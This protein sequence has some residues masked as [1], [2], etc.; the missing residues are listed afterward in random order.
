MCFLLPSAL[1]I[2]HES[3]LLRQNDLRP[4]YRLGIIHLNE[5]RMKRYREETARVKR[6]ASPTVL[7][8]L[9]VSAPSA[10]RGWSLPVIPRSSIVARTLDAIP[11][12]FGHAALCILAPAL[13]FSPPPPILLPCNAIDYS[14]I[15]GQTPPLNP[16]QRKYRATLESGSAEEV[17]AANESLIDYAVGTVNTMYY[18]PTGGYN[19]NS[20]SFYAN[21]SALRACA[22]GG[23]EGL[24]RWK[25][26]ER[27]RIVRERADWVEIGG[28]TDSESNPPLP[29][30]TNM[31][32]Q[33]FATREGSVSAINWLVSTLRDPYSKYLTK[34]ELVTELKYT[35]RGFMDSGAIVEA[36]Q[37]APDTL[38]IRVTASSDDLLLKTKVLAASREKNAHFPLGKKASRKPLGVIDVANLPV[39][40][41]VA[42]DSI[43]ERTGVVVGDR[44]VGVSGKV[45]FLGIGREEVVKRLAKYNFEEAVRPRSILVAKPIV[46]TEVEKARDR[47]LGYRV[48]RLTLLPSET[49]A[50]PLAL[51]RSASAA[52]IEG[53]DSIVHYKL[54]QSSDSFFRRSPFGPNERVVDKLSNERSS[55]GYIRLTRFSRAATSGY[56]KAVR[57]LEAAG[58]QS[59]ILDIRNNYGG[60]VQEAM[61]TA[62]TLLRDPHSVLIY[63]QNSR[64]G[65]GPQEVEKYLVDKRFPGYFLSSEPPWVTIEDA[66]KDDPEFFKEEGASSWSPPSMY[67]SL[68]EQGVKRNLHRTTYSSDI[69]E[70]SQLS[71][72]VAR[73]SE[74]ERKSVLAQKKVVLLMNEGTASS[75]EVFAAAL[76]D[77]GRLVAS[78]GSKTYGKGLI[79]HTFPMPDGGGLRIVVAEYLTP[80][81]KHVT[82]VG[83]A[84]YDEYGE[85]V[86]GGVRPDIQCSSTSGIPEDIG[87]DICVG[88]ALDALDAAANDIKASTGLL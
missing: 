19:F 69:G 80:A 46:G 73:M 88:V 34:E 26:A 42:P 9:L 61:L 29:E 45:Q 7:L 38:Q 49:E 84:R 76:H 33:A 27:R 28:G 4:Y 77:N 15:E 65:F 2:V 48:S 51:V 53:G 5:G 70:D 37:D 86:G 54:L 10:S 36:P 31:P 22:K 30:L 78:V 17:A 24:E 50:H 8:F 13:I 72:S 68:R 18:D 55:V 79:L 32:R 3:T 57:E 12:T 41:A 23:S 87:A 6:S 11:T 67:A 14:M 1:L 75:A 43:A 44:I 40:T 74:K 60:I 16:A 52:S 66:K 20:R 83:G 39:V 71:A 59:Y 35:S 85:M 25:I 63:T 82:R 56:V 64:G 58:A 81:L 47:V 62:S 21:W